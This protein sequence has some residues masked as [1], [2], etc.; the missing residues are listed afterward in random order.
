MPV[1]LPPV[2]AYIGVNAS[3]RYP[4]KRKVERS[5]RKRKRRES[6]LGWSKRTSRGG[7]RKARGSKIDEQSSPFPRGENLETHPR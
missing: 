6:S 3:R 2:A 7:K 1:T 4:K 5:F